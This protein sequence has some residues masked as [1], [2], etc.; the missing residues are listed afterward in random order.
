[1]FDDGLRSMHTKL[2]PAKNRIQDYRVKTFGKDYI[3]AMDNISNRP[4]S[5]KLWGSKR[6]RP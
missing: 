2:A 3:R 4:K 5:A 1:M 6:E